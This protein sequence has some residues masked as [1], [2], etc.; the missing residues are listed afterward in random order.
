MA[1][2]SAVRAAGRMV[3]WQLAADDVSTAM[4]NSF[5]AT[6][7]YEKT[8]NVLPFGQPREN[9]FVTKNSEFYLQDSWKVNSK[10]TV[11]YGLHYE[12]DS[13]PYDVNGLQVTTTPGL[14]SYFAARA[15][16]ANYHHRR[17]PG[18]AARSPHRQRKP[19]L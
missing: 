15:G 6:Y 5:S 3:V 13:V 2:E 10:L 8:G 19:A 16:A 18:A 1:I 17:L 9:D 11:N 4:I 7:Q 14:D 12:Y